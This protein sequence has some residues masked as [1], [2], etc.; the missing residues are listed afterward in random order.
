MALR[1]VAQQHAALLQG[2]WDALLAIG[3]AGA[4][5][6]PAVPQSPR[7]QAGAADGTLPEKV[8]QQS[9]R[10]PGD[11]LQAAD[12][13]AADAGAAGAA[14]LAAAAAAEQWQ[15]VADQVLPLAVQH[16]SPL[17]R[18][19]GQAVVGALTPAAFASLPPTLQLQLLG[20]CCSAT[21]A[22]EASPVRAAAAKAVGAIAAAPALCSVP[23][24]EAPFRGALLG[25]A[26]V[27]TV[28]FA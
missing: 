24:G 26:C 28:A 22:D 15:Q 20:W 9:V 12:A 16:S 7:A 2:C 17:L 21:V 25:G 27:Q 19:A 5:V 1:G 18:A 13:A 8:A 23:N 10:L 6:P 14:G 3:R 4:A 11:Y